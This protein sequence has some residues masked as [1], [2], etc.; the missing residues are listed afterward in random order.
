MSTP[1]DSALIKHEIYRSLKALEFKYLQLSNCDF[2]CKGSWSL[3]I[4]LLT[5]IQKILHRFN[6]L[7]DHNINRFRLFLPRFQLWCK[8]LKSSNSSDA[9]WSIIPSLEDLFE[10][11]KPKSQFILNP[12]YERKYNIHTTNILFDIKTKILSNP[13]LFVEPDDDP[14][15]FTKEVFKKI[16]CDDIYIISF[17]IIKRLSV[18]HFPILG[19]E[20]GH[21]FYHDWFIKYFN[22]LAIKNNFESHIDTFVAKIIKDREKNQISMPFFD[23]K[24]MLASKC[25]T[26]YKRCFEEIFCDIIGTMIF[27]YTFLFGVYKFSSLNNREIQYIDK[28]YYSWEYRIRICLDVLK[29]YGTPYNGEDYKII[30]KWINEIDNKFDKL[31]IYKKIKDNKEY[32]FHTAML[33]TIDASFGEI[34]KQI[35]PYVKDVMFSDIYNQNL[36]SV[37]DELLSQ[38]IIPCVNLKGDLSSD[39]ITM[40]NIIVGTWLNILSLDYNVLSTDEL[41]KH[42]HRINLLSL[43]GIE[44]SKETEKYQQ[45][46]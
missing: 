11:I 28:G 41:Y 19:H 25:L 30:Q 44:L 32:N 3:S 13:G 39:P 5:I 45:N 38:N 23:N 1:S 14:S 18:L 26:T 35:E 21:L 40:R 46:L 10:K 6:S 15:S 17:P 20:I 43:K 12:T 33:D 34:L 2:A 9:P 4:I 27:G 24:E 8:Y 42:I 29:H 7:S 31:V 36:I 37:V 16:D 22:D